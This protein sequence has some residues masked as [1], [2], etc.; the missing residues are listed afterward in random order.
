[1]KLLPA[2]EQRIGMNEQWQWDLDGVELGAL[3]KMELQIGGH[4][5]LG[6]VVEMDRQHYWISHEEC[7]A[8][9]ISFLMRARWPST[10]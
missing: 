6:T 1:M 7:V 2:Q 3:Q 4:W 9:P 10:T 8:I 5:I